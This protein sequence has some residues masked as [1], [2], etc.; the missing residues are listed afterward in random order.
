VKGAF[1]WPLGVLAALLCVC[2]AHAAAAGAL[3][4]LP[5]YDHVFVL[6]LENESYSSSFGSSSPAHYLNDTLVPEGVLDDQYYATGHVSL[7]NYIA[8]TS[9]QPSN[10][11]TNTDCAVVSIYIC[12]QSTLAFSNGANIGDQL[13]A[14]GAGWKGYMDTMPAACFHQDYSPTTTSP[15]PYQGDSTSP[16]AFDYADRH[17]PF[18]YYPDIVGDNARCQAHDVPYADSS[19]GLAADIAANTV[20]GFGF[21]TPDTCHDGHDSPCANGDP[22]GLVSADAWLQSNVPPLLAYL[23]AH[24]G[25]LIITFDEGSPSDLSGCCHGGPGGQQGEGGRVGLV[26]LGPG[27]KA[28]QVVHTAYDHASLMRTVEDLFGISAYLNNA[29]VSSP[30]SDLFQAPRSQ[31]ADAP[32]TLAIPLLGLAAAGAFLG[33]KRSAQQRS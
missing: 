16:P 18:I 11:V 6:I 10:L 31:V 17:N 7:D 8:M 28:G 22:G 9:A 29:A 2:P 13:D 1:R 15:D 27:V 32:L 26:A 14:V 20:P 25:L 4:G 21:I 3:E 23:N 12:A 30:M 33:R 24:N 5:S 19:A